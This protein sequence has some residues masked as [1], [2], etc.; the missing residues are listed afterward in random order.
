MLTQRSETRKKAYWR[1]IETGYYMKRWLLGP[2]PWE[3][4]SAYRTVNEYHIK[5]ANSFRYSYKICAKVPATFSEDRSLWADGLCI[6]CLG[7]WAAERRE[8]ST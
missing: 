2:P 3:E 1:Y 4:D 8:N 5:A 6:G 7:Q